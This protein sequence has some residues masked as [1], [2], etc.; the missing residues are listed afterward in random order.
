M[1]PDVLLAGVDTIKVN[2]KECDPDGRLFKTQELSEDQQMVFDAL[3]H[4]AQEFG[5]PVETPWSFCQARLVMLPNGSPTFRYILKNDCVNIAIAPRLTI[6][7]LAKVTLSS[8]YLWSVGNPQKA[9]RLVHRFL[10]ELFGKTIYLQAGQIDLCV[11]VVGLDLPPDWQEVFVSLARAKKPIKESQKDREYYFGPKL[12]TILFSGHGNP[13]NG[14]LYDKMK[15]IKQHGN[16]KDWFY[17]LWKQYGQW[18]GETK[19]WREEFSLE[20]AGLSEMNMD[21]IYETI[22][23]IKRLWFYCTHEWL[24]MVVPGSDSNRRRWPTAP[25]WQKIQRAFDHFEGATIEEMGRL[26]RK[27]KR[28]ANIQRGVAA[29]A[30]YITTLGAW[31]SDLP[32]DGDI[33]ALFHM[34]RSR[35]EKRWTKTGVDLQAT[36]TAKKFIYSQ[37]A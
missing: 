28:E 13:V 5:K 33:D 37:E 8:P 2:V 23:N 3:Q 9:V 29:I 34:V 16:E 1:E 27:R 10:Q 12:E 21:D 11:D 36:I 35:I 20:R 24:R 14:K 31:D 4:H 25:I 6:P 22:H 30:G 15:E 7:I 26:V 17:P 18:D 19:V 32:N